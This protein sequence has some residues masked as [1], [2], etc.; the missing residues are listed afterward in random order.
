MSQ[1][2]TAQ[3]ILKIIKAIIFIQ[4]IMLNARAAGTCLLDKSD[5]AED[6]KKIN[7]KLSVKYPTS[8][9]QNVALSQTDLN[10]IYDK[11]LL[12]VDR[13]DKFLKQAN[14]VGI[15]ANGTADAKT[16]YAS[17]VLIS[18]CHVLVNAHAVASK[19]AKQGKEAVYISLGQST[20]DSKNE[21][22]YQDLKGKVI[23]IGD[24]SNDSQEISASKD[25]A[26]VRI[27]EIPDIDPALVSTEFITINDSIATIGFPFSAT[28]NQKTGLRYPTLN[29]TRKT[30]VGMNGTFKILNNENL[31]GASGAGM[32][33]LD[34]NENDDAQL[35][36]GGIFIG[37]KKDGSGG[38]GLQTPAILQHLKATNLA[39]YNELKSSIQRHSCK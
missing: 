20:C 25:Y 35:V 28:F 11:Q 30:A 36:L 12:K 15:I 21:F 10:K 31:P 29:F 14:S 37:P 38:T 2:T 18:P 33:V 19:E 26:I 1:N 24:A 34:K 17:A 16:E 13:S 32:F 23:A 7:Q 27:S 39:A 9:F 8:G 4:F 22:L 6:M 3:N 5:I